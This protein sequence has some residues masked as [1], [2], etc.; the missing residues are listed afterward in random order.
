MCVP[1]RQNTCVCKN[2]F[3]RTISYFLRTLAPLCSKA[4]E[5][6][7]IVRN[8]IVCKKYLPPPGPVCKHFFTHFLRTLAS[9]CGQMREC[10]TMYIG[11]FLIRLWS[12]GRLVVT[13]PDCVSLG[14]RV[15]IFLRASVCIYVFFKRTCVFLYAWLYLLHACVYFYTGIMFFTR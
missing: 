9:L 6:V 7:K 8:R 12:L 13:W 10:V 15:C 4:G 5:C 11:G 14:G 3:F 1:L 2:M